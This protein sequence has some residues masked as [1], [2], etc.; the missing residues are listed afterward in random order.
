MLKVVV[1]T[2][3][4]IHVYHGNKGILDFIPAE[5]EMADRFRETLS[6]A[7]MMCMNDEKIHAE[8]Y[9]Y[10]TQEL[11]DIESGEK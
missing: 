9:V 2:G 11:E 10:G 3:G 1:E 8:F 5:V 6:V 7:V 4:W